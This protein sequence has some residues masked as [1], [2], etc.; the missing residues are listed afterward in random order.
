MI[1]DE[2]VE[3]PLVTDLDTWR[4]PSRVIGTLYV[5]KFVFGPKEPKK[6]KVI[7]ELE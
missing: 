7:V 6:V 2:C 3:T 4:S 1:I 5:Q